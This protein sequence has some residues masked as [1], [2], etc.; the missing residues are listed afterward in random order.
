[1]GGEL[2]PQF[3]INS[4]IWDSIKDLQKPKPGLACIIED[5]YRQRRFYCKVADN[6]SR[7][8]F[9]GIHLRIMLF[10]SCQLFVDGNE[11]GMEVGMEV[12]LTLP[13]VCQMPPR[14]FF[15][16]QPQGVNNGEDVS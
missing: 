7:R 4:A 11:V 10:G 12:G 13:Q 15:G 8:I 9:Y 6:I 1:M 14:L 5:E 16:S 3:H 2:T